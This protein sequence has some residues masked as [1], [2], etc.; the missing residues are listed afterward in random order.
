MSNIPYVEPFDV[1]VG[2]VIGVLFMLGANQAASWIR[3][4]QPSTATVIAHLQSRTEEL[5]A[6]KKLLEAEDARL[7]AEREAWFKAELARAEEEY[8]KRIP[9]EVQSI[10]AKQVAAQAQAKAEAQ[11]GLREARMTIAERERENAQLST[12]LA[13]A[14]ADLTLAK[15]TV[16]KLQGDLGTLR[17]QL[18]E[19]QAEV[20]AARAD[21]ARLTKYKA[22]FDRVRAEAADENADLRVL[23]RQANDQIEASGSTVASLQASLDV[24]LREKQALHASLAQTQAGLRQVSAT[25]QNAAHLEQYVVQLQTSLQA[26]NQ[27]RCRLLQEVQHLIGLLNRTTSRPTVWRVSPPVT[28]RSSY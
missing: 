5:A 11:T 10:V 13:Q 23:L 20:A 14:Q 24:A 12:L 28:A 26:V 17:S 9:L 1:G 3:D 15:R 8:K 22:G 21:N 27:E 6:E 4:D 7:D 18:Q 25:A 2:A 19:A 16:E